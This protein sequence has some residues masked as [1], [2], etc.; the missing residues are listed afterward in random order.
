[1]RVIAAPCIGRCEQA[2]AVSLGQN[3]FGHATCSS[4]IE[5][6]EAGAVKAQTP[7]YLNY[8]DYRANGGYAL[9]QE[10]VDGVH[11]VEDL[12]Q[13]LQDSG[14]RGLGGAGFPAARKWRIVRAEAAPRLMAVNLDEGEP[15]TFKDR[16]YLEQD[17]HR[18]LEGMLIAGWAV[19]VA[20]IYLYIRDE[21]HACR[22]ML[23]T[24]LAQLKANPPIQNCPVIHLRRGA[25]A[26]NLR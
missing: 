19:G 16:V 25:G 24:E 10:C 13:I 26:Y 23:E 11:E 15:G 12:L 2:P 7:A 8:A 18:F 20:E 4:I 17:P 6:V 21:Y 14:L 5:Q 9:L 3:A 22:L 1:V